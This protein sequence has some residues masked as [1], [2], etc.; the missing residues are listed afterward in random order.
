MSGFNFSNNNSVKK[1]GSPIINH[2]GS[3]I[4]MGG[5]NNGPKKL[6]IK[7]LRQTPKAPVNYEVESWEKLSDAVQ[8]IHNKQATQLTLEELYRMVENL[9]SE[10]LSS[11]LYLKLSKQIEQNT[12]K[13]LSKL[14]GLSTDLFTFLTMVN[15][16][17]KDH[18]NHL[19]M[20]RSIFLCLDRTYVIQN[21]DIKSIWDLGLY[22]F[23]IYLQTL[24]ELEKK[25]NSGLLISIEK[26][27]KGDSMDRDLLHSL[28]KMLSSLQ[29]YQKFEQDFLEESNLFYGNEG[30]HYIN[31]NEVPQYLEHVENRIKEEND[32]SMRYLDPSTRKS[33]IGVLE[34]QLLGEKHIK[35][36][37][38]KGFHSLMVENRVKD[39]TKLY[40]LFQR[41][42]AIQPYL[43]ESWGKYIRQEGQLMVS[44]T[45]KD[46][47]LIQDLLDFKDRLDVILHE[48][49]HK[50]EILTYSL[51]ESFEYFI[52]TRANKPAELI[53]KFID[54]KLKTGNKRM[55]EEEI[56]II[57]NKS[58]ILFRYVQGKDVFE[59]FYKQDLSKRLLLDK[60]TSIDAEKSMIQ[61]LKTECGTVFTAKLEDM[62]KDIDLSNDTMDAFKLSP[63]IEAYKHIDMNIYVLSHGNWP[64]P[65]P[66]E[67][68]IPKEFT[69]YQEVFKKFYTQK[70]QGRV[71]Q[72]QNSVSHCV[73]KANFPLGKKEIF[74]S[75]FQTLILFLFNDRD[76]IS[77]REIKDTTGIEEE[78]LKRNL[79]ALTHSKTDVLVKRS[80]SKTIDKD[81]IFNY[82]KKFTHKLMR[83]KINAIQAQETKEENKKTN[84]NILQ[85]RQYQIDA[86]IVRIMKDRKVLSHNLLMSELFSMLKFTPKPVDLKKRIESLIEREYLGRDP[87]NAM[88]YN[89]LA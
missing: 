42:N 54:S 58:L 27:R 65:P 50:N 88:N 59:A 79:Q 6:V 83:I 52:N 70:Y 33:L 19:I 11:S 75:L 69:E 68:N 24:P 81:E 62:F 8:S 78:E 67:A 40:N 15:S 61:K 16:C 23:R 28:I 34:R 43:K 86:A 37:L 7:N 48:A 51:K 12:K 87:E 56:E 21:T 9:C 32:R 60:S 73:L 76:E 47:T 36:I 29:I 10:K 63:Y 35:L 55:T 38:S 25:V 41:V 2:G 84:E 77:Y 5:S 20:I 46:D 82:N 1:T 30:M 3:G 4:H 57:L 31:E 64:L 72:W 74:V 14:V 53:A 26:E 85:D 17:W 66:I 13:E 39:L 71:L 49:F 80:K 18:S 44:D 89:Y 45:Q 22:Y